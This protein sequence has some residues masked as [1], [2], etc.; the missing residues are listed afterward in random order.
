[1]PI[2]EFMPQHAKRIWLNRFC[3]HLEM[4]Q[5]SMNCLTA[6]K[7]ALA[8]FPDA[9]HLEPEEAAEVFAAEPV[10]AGLGMARASDRMRALREVER[11]QV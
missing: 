1:M 9:A 2:P 3:A 7:H 8:V 6:V 5:P 11:L 10:P 4:L